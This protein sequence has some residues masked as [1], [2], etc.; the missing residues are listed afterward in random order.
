MFGFMS[1]TACCSLPLLW[2]LVAALPSAEGCAAG[3]A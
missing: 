3:A 2:L 1:T